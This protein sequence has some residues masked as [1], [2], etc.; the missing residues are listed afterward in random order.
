MLQRRYLVVVVAFAIAAGI[1]VGVQQ[2]LSR[3]PATVMAGGREC[4]A[5]RAAIDAAMG[6]RDDMVRIEGGSFTM[7]SDNSRP[8]EAPAR[9]AEVGAFWIDRY[10][11]TNEEFAAFVEATGY[12]TVA[13]RPADPAA[14]PGIDPSLLVPGA[15]VF[16]T[17][18]NVTNMEDISQ[19]WNYVPGADWR[20]PEGPDSS[21]E[22]RET[23]PVVAVTREDALAYAQ[24]LGR[25]LPTEAEWEFAARGGISDAEYVWGDDK[26]PGGEWQANAW[27]G[28]FPVIDE[29]KDGF[30]G[31][32]PVGCF[33][34]NGYGLY[35][36]A[37]NVWE[38]TSDD[39]ADLRGM[40]PGMV[41]IKGGSYLCA[42]NYCLR[43]RPAARQPA[44][45]DVGTNH[46]GFRTVLRDDGSS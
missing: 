18:A 21:I 43:Y 42:D 45:F 14:N 35:D 5:D 9:P 34:A 10:E 4:A 44:S 41:V 25:D 39:Y 11:V 38:L 37:G 3:E 17:P 24:W 12:V 40:R 20:H 6:G 30:A 28:V 27:Q 13:E 46:I 16:I 7:G 15:V 23:Y 32:A 1:G 36:M 31:S 26:I 33:S 29:V 2:Y 22:G 8:E 19:W